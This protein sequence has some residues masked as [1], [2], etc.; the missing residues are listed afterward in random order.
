MV[1]TS[2]VL[3]FHD[4]VEI[5]L[6]QPCI[7][8]G[9]KNGVGKSRVLR[10]IAKDAP[11]ERVYINLHT[12]AEQA[13]RVLRSRDDL[14]EMV[15]EY[16]PLT[17]DDD[18]TSISKLIVGREYESIEWY[19]LEIEPANEDDADD[20]LWTDDEPVLPFFRV[21]Y[22]GMQYSA[23]E[24]GQG[25]FCVHFLFWILEK[26]KERSNLLLLLDEPDAF[27][28]PVGA[29]KLL[30]C[31]LHLC[32]K[33]NWKV[34]I[35]THSEEMIRLSRQHE[36]FVLLQVDNDGRTVA[37]ASSIDPNA[38]NTL[39]A[40]PPV[41]QV[42][43]CEDESAY[44]LLS[45]LLDANEAAAGRPSEIVWGTGQGCLVALEKALPRS[46]APRVNFA[47]VFD[48]DQRETVKSS[49]GRRWPIVF[50]PTVKDPDTLFMDLRADKPAIA[51]SLGTSVAPLSEFLDS[52]E[53]QDPHDWVN[54]LGERYGRQ[55]AL[56][57]LS[58][59]W[60]SQ[61]PAEVEPF[62]TQLQSADR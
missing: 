58:A 28:P 24:M 1:R 13:L 49:V 4:G 21:E 29:H 38:G 11:K 57:Q 12:L 60:C 9:G 44:F 37:T 40:S 25:E 50:L 47:Y 19:D 45:A 5:D 39:L 32:L 43:F 54:S 6:A 30:M 31:I 46:P 35:S 33:R 34:V 22:R 14:N 48:G 41:Q 56:R 26:F 8:L 42:L 36:G 61:N 51:H 10:S 52:I 2:Q 16:T 20:F 23:K 7:V 59:L 53:G 3:T 18:V 15:E 27:L 17:L 62:V 55:F